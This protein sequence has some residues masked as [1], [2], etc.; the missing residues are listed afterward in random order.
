MNQKK[1]DFPWLTTCRSRC[2]LPKSPDGQAITFVAL[3]SEC[4]TLDSARRRLISH[5]VICDW[6]QFTSWWSTN[7]YGLSILHE[8][9]KAQQCGWIEDACCFGC[10]F[11]VSAFSKAWM[12][13]S[14][15]S[16][17]IFV[18]SVK[19][20]IHT[21][22][23]SGSVRKRSNQR[24]H[25]DRFG[26]GCLH[27]LSKDSEIRRVPCWGHTCARTARRMQHCSVHKSGSSCDCITHECGWKRRAL[28]SVPQPV[29]ST[30]K[31]PF[32]GH[33]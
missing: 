2:W 27:A 7:W 9:F 30:K 29:F 3:V 14:C 18:S 17:F 24:I 8:Q 6:P 13:W 10:S 33:D 1:H 21:D 11:Q 15:Y 28:K 26:K 32:S 23:L 16:V 5:S 12:Y 20:F 22:P 4:H 31:F 19:T 25:M